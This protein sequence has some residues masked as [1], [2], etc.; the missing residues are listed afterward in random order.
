MSNKLFIG[1]LLLLKSLYFLI[2]DFCERFFK[3]LEKLVRFEIC[4]E[5][6]L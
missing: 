2:L 3:V 6:G 5:F 1:Q 4:S